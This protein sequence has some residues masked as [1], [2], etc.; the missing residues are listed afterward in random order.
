M[1]NNN[2][3]AS[4]SR[5]SLGQV[6]DLFKDQSTEEAAIKQ[7][8]YV[9]GIILT[10]ITLFGALMG[11]KR[12]Y[13]RFGLPNSE[14]PSLGDT[15]PIM[16]FA[17]L[18]G[19]IAIWVLIAIL[20]GAVLYF[21]G[22][23][24]GAGIG[25]WAIIVIMIVNLIGSAFVF[26]FFNRWQNAVN[27]NLVEK[28]R[29]GSAR[30]A[31][32]EDLSDLERQSGLY[33]GGSIYGYS[34]KGHILTLGG[35]RGGKGVNCI[36]PNL[37]DLGGYQGSWFVIDVKGELSAIS[38]RC[39]RAKGQDVYVLDPWGLNTTNGATYNPLDLVADQ[40]DPDSLIDDISIIAEMIVPK[41][42]K[43]EQFW[44]NKARSFIAALIL[45]LM[46]TVEKKEQTLAKIWTW[47]RLPIAEFEEL[48][49]DLAVSDSAIVRAAGNEYVSI[50]HTSEKMF[51]SI[52]AVAQEKT[53]FLKS[54]A[55][56]KSLASSNFDVKNITN[57]KTT[58]YVI[59]PPDKLDSHY[60][61]L[62]LVM[63]TALRS[64]VRNHD[65]RITFLLD[66]FAALGYLPEMKTAL[67]TYAGYN[68]TMWPIVQDFGQLQSLYGQSWET[69]ISNTAV[70]QFLSVSDV[71]S[72]EYLS[73][74][75][76]MTTT[77][78]YDPNDKKAK[79]QATARPLATPDEI[80]RASADNVF[81]LIEQ[82]PVACFEKIPYYEMPTLK[83]KYDHNPYYKQQNKQ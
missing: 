21:A 28:G 61:W 48:L 37:L 14:Q 83:G 72:L 29:F 12:A 35:T 4:S 56:Q 52:L 42:S 81:A 41:D 39:Q 63:T 44:S 62:R 75:M 77:V 79:A 43:G 30:W 11:Y 51:Q 31:D 9:V 76:G 54:P 38:A 73:K 1:Q 6:F 71:F 65:K 34:Q 40:T 59:I 49:A 26:R 24:I 50:I 80:R 82:R 69:F 10:P 45:H 64:A 16:W 53:D 57:G 32:N 13:N 60:Q 46:M 78:T 33:I 22:D 36:L 67:S 17:M 68:I 19:A 55:L 15:K 3:S 27:G 5:M 25:T 66:E 23:V 47:L 20:L 8:L 2:K 18:L 74:L 70:R 58:L 7:L